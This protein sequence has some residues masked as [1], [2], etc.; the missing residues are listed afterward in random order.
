MSGV[1]VVFFEKII[2]CAGLVGFG[3]KSIFHLKA[4]FE[5]K[6]LS[7]AFD[8]SKKIGLTSSGGVASKE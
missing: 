2:S 5:I 1:T 8:I 6:T 3:L 7:R 4:H